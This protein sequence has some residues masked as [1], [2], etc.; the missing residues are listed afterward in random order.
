MIGDELHVLV[1]STRAS[2]RAHTHTHTHTHTHIY[3]HSHT[4]THT[5]S[6]SL[7]L[8]L[9]LC[10]PKLSPACTPKCEMQHFKN[11]KQI[12][13]HS[14]KWLLKSAAQEGNNST[15]H[16]VRS[17]APSYCHLLLPPSAPIHNCLQ[18]C[19]HLVSYRNCHFIVNFIVVCNKY[20]CRRNSL[21]L[22][23]C[24]ARNVEL[25]F[26]ARDCFRRHDP[27]SQWGQFFEWLCGIRTV[28]F[29]KQYLRCKWLR[30]F[31][32]RTFN[33]GVYRPHWEV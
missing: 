10:K 30:T 23:M 28:N 24:N 7:S 8:S 32:M 12:S 11:L 19:H 26:A 29:M 15:E 6:L 13:R 3:T 18:R 27:P 14:G 5:L 2:A 22:L 17:S 4:H 31:Y 1:G 21:R 9:F 20:N 25:T 33:V 16:D